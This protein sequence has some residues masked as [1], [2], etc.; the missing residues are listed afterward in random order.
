MTFKGSL[1]FLDTS[2]ISDY[3]IY[4]HFLL[5]CE[6]SFY[7]FEDVLW[8]TKVFNF[9]DVCCLCVPDLSPLP[10]PLS[11]Y[12][13]SSGFWLGQGAVVLWTESPSPSVCSFFIEP[14]PTLSPLAHSSLFHSSL[15][16]GWGQ[17][18]PA[19]SPSPAPP[20]FSPSQ[21]QLPDTPAFCFTSHLSDTRPYPPRYS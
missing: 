20:M 6:L 7:F 2:P 16:P 13:P 1:Y 19:A 5:V 15:Y 11:P 12:I 4:K 3:M 8:N 9:D 14:S 17:P 18:P 10:L 21:G